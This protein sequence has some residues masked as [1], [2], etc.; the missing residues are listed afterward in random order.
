MN[1]SASATMISELSPWIVRGS[2]PL[3][4]SDGLSSKKLS[5]DSHSSNPQ[6]PGQTG[7]A[8]LTGPRCHLPKC[9]VA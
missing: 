2:A 1:F 4:L 7:E 6:A 3:R 9:P 8:A 5:C